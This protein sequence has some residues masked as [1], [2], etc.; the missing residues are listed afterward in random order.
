MSGLCNGYEVKSKLE[1]KIHDL[2]LDLILPTAVKKTQL[3]LKTAQKD[4]KQTQKKAKESGNKSLEQIAARHEDAGKK[5][6]AKI[7]KEIK[8]AEKIERMWRKFK[9]TRS[10]GKKSSSD[11]KRKARSER[12][13]QVDALETAPR[14]PLHKNASMSP[15]IMGRQLQ[16]DGMVLQRSPSMPRMHMAKNRNPM[17]A[18]K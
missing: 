1:E 2:G 10:K 8:S 17:L 5:S 9:S 12:H 15:Q 13:L 11:V 18:M 6:Q 4:I 16:N 14:P 7:I 3:I